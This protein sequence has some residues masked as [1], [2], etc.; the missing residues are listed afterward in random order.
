MGVKGWTGKANIGTRL[1]GFKLKLVLC[2]LVCK[3]PDGG[4]CWNLLGFDSDCWK[5]LLEN[6]DDPRLAM[7]TIKSI[8]WPHASNNI[9]A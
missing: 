4:S 1:A 7:L 2:L 9:S 6:Q 5:L 3:Q 8:V